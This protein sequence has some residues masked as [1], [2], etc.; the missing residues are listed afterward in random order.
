MLK[1]HPLIQLAA[2]ALALYVLF[3]GVQR[4]RFLHLKQKTKFPWRRHATW[5]KITMAAWL[6]GLVGGLVMTRLTW[7]GFLI[8]GAHAWIGLS[9]GTLVVFGLITGIYMDRVKKTRKVLPLIHGLNNT[10]VV[11]L[12]L[13]QIYTGWMVYNAFVLGN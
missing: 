7:P 4:F 3:W 9:L 1:I 2:T 11:L 10:L 6:A 13:I 8:T 5:G 12:A